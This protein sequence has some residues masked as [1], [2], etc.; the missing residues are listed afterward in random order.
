MEVHAGRPP[1]VLRDTLNGDE[2]AHDRGDD[3]CPGRQANNQPRPDRAATGFVSP[4][5]TRCAHQQ[6]GGRH[7]PTS[8]HARDALPAPAGCEPPSRRPLTRSWRP[9]RTRCWR[10]GPD[11]WR[12]RDLRRE[13]TVI[14][15]FVSPFITIPGVALQLVAIPIL[16]KQV[17]S[18]VRLGGGAHAVGRDQDDHAL[19]F[20]PAL[21]TSPANLLVGCGDYLVTDADVWVKD[22][23]HDGVGARPGR[24]GQRRPAG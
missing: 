5:L 3:C 24:A 21:L 22:W 9:R 19:P 4:S 1:L 13:L 20:R 2:Q 11:H 23:E 10:S 6:A 15:R 17:G 12:A 14:R 16:G 8:R 18:S 7:V